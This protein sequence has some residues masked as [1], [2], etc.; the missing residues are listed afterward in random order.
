MN[1]SAERVSHTK[2]STPNRTL[3]AG[4]ILGMLIGGSGLLFGPEK[5]GAETTPPPGTEAG[6]NSPASYGLAYW[7]E[8]LQKENTEITAARA[9]EEAAR[10]RA[11]VR[12]SLNPPS[13][14]VEYKQAPLATFPNPTHEAME[15][16]YFIQQDIMFPGKLLSMGGAE[17]HGADKLKWEVELKIREM[18]RE[19]KATYYELYELARKRTFNQRNREL[20]QQLQG[21]VERQYGLGRGSLSDVY[22]VQ[23]EYSTLVSQAM[24]LE[25]AQKATLAEFNALLNRPVDV[26]IRIIPPALP[27]EAPAYRLADLAARAEKNQPELKAAQAE[28]EMQSSEHAASLWAFFPDVMVK[29]MYMDMRG[30]GENAWALMGAVTLPFAP[31]ALPQT[32]ATVSQSAAQLRQSRAEYQSVHNRLK[33]QLVRSLA[34]VEVSYQVLVLNRDTILRQA[35]QTWQTTLSAYQTNQQDFLRL[36]DAY[37]TL[38]MAREN[39]VMAEKTYWTRLADL[40]KIVGSDLLSTESEIR[41]TQ[42]EVKP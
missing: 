27:T 32:V 36:L 24:I 2:P 9:A 38:W 37:R 15:V 25:Q 8:V 18:I 7:V 39:L 5:V 23:T 30:G 4:L 42:E 21:I 11:W 26:P 12:G 1:D 28:V 41:L 33:V 6:N 14:G 20:V 19:L 17:G 34:E 40:E 10:A 35:E 31:W 22:R 13:V 29:G 3:R 16:D